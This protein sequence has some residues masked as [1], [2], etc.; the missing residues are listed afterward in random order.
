MK[1]FLDRYAGLYLMIV[2]WIIFAIIMVLV[3][4]R[5]ILFD[6]GFDYYLHMERNNVIALALFILTTPLPLFGNQYLDAIKKIF[7]K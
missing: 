6:L 1:K 4:N 3:A 7:K 2:Y 5:N